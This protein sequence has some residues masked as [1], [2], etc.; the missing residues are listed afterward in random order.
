[1]D[2]NKL[3]KQ[4]PDIQ[5]KVGAQKIEYAPA[6][7]ELWRSRNEY[8]S[9]RWKGLFELLSWTLNRILNYLFALNTGGLV[10]SLTYIATKPRTNLTT[11]SIIFFAVGILLILIHAT[12]HY[13]YAL[14]LFNEYKTDVAQYYENKFDWGN[15]TARDEDR[16]ERGS[17]RG[18]CFGWGSGIA[19]VSGLYCGIAALFT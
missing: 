1:M 2:N 18:F 5:S 8:I 4:S 16:S 13:Y 11:I 12:W 19:F 17:W 10:A 6:Q 7:D 9:T 14:T 15:L 3:T